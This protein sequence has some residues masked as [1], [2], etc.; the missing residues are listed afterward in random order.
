MRAFKAAFALFL[1]ATLSISPA[2]AERT[3]RVIAMRGP[4]TWID[5]YDWAPSYSKRPG[6]SA[7][8]MKSIAATGVKTVFIQ[9]ARSERTA[10][11]VDPTQL[12]KLM[13]A[14]KTNGLYVVLWYLPAYRTTDIARIK[15]MVDLRPDGIALDVESRKAPSD[16]QVLDLLTKS[17]ALVPPPTPLMVAVYPPAGTAVTGRQTWQGFPWRKAAPLVDVWAVMAYWR[18]DKVFSPAAALYAQRSLAA[19]EGAL[20]ADTLI[21]VIG[22]VATKPD[23]ASALRALVRQNVIGASIY[24]W[25]SSS[26]AAHRALTAE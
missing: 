23:Q 5:V 17:R 24:D 18:E 19:I 16:T 14:A 1:V 8:T 7:S 9:A 10:V 13:A 3:D 21:H 26:A 4:G 15:A 20:P 11:L 12:K 22:G 6:V 2:Q 25:R